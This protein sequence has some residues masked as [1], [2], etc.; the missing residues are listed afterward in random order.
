MHFIFD[1]LQGIGI[2]A[3]IGIR[4]FLPVLLA[5]ALAAADLGLDFDHT[6][7]SFLEGVPFLL[8]ILVL[9]AAFA[10]LERRRPPETEGAGTSPLAAMLLGVAL[11]LGALLACGSL[12]DRSS[13]WWPGLIAG[14]LAVGLAYAATRSL[15]GRVRRRLD[16]E[17]ASALPLYAEGAALLAAGLS[18]LLPPLAILV[19]GALAW[20]LVAGRRRAE[21]K[22]AGLR[23]LR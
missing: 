17:T 10:V 1:L 11:V 22:Y 5:G 14:P 23:I 20:L 12:D 13:T 8:V 6:S 15:L 7:F 4:P 3:A 18:I 21:R 16:A 9:V 19:V 2:A